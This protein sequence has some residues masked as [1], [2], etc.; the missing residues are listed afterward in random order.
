MRLLISVIFIAFLIISCK[1]R[2]NDSI[3]PSPNGPIIKP[4]SSL[5]DFKFIPLSN[6]KWVIKFVGI[7]RVDSYGRWYFDSSYFKTTT[8][9]TTGNIVIYK[10]MNFIEYKTSTVFGGKWWPHT[11]TGFLY[12]RED[13][14][15]QKLLCWG[16]IMNVTYPNVDPLID[17]SLEVGDT[18]MYNYVST[19]TISIVD[20]ILIGGQYCKKWIEKS[21][22]GWSGLFQAYGIGKRIGILPLGLYN[23]D[24]EQVVSL[25]FYHKTD[26]IHFAYR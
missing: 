13:T 14:I 5:K 22:S 24:G 8:I 15:K 20:S 21:T 2:P 9:L 1:R 18:T 19:S 16:K 4:D 10:S 6:A 7:S 17:F 23:S 12:V 25:D 26:S 11:D 3:K